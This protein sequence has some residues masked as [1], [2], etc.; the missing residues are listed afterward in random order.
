MAEL[1]IYTKTKRAW[2]NELRQ[3][4]ISTYYKRVEEATYS[5]HYGAN[6]VKVQRIKQLFT[7]KF[8]PQEKKN[9]IIAFQSNNIISYVNFS[10]NI[11]GKDYAVTQKSALF[12]FLGIYGKLCMHAWRIVVDGTRTMWTWWDISQSL[13]I[14]QNSDRNV[15]LFWWLWFLVQED[16]QNPLLYHVRFCFWTGT[17]RLV[18]LCPSEKKKERAESGRY[19]IRFD[20]E[21]G[22]GTAWEMRHRHND[23]GV[24]YP[25]DG[26]RKQWGRSKVMGRVL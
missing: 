19:R 13:V 18:N 15:L 1:R 2:V 25:Q 17:I 5:L 16:T 12:R 24:V 14:R 11:G 23:G 21:G 9:F 4:F 22:K 3:Y 26:G 8:W 6:G 20:G 7:S 10:L